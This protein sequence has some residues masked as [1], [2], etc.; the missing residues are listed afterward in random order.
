MIPKKA[1]NWL[2]ILWIHELNELTF[3]KHLDRVKTLIR[4]DL[5]SYPKLQ[6]ISKDC[7]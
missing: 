6:K 2:H 5:D 4:Y 7:F 1:P 3:D